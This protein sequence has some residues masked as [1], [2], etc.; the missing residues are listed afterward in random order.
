MNLGNEAPVEKEKLEGAPDDIEIVLSCTIFEF[1]NGS[2]KTF[3]FTRDKLQPDGRSM[4][5]EE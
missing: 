5:Q 2:L 3:A 1:Y 4:D